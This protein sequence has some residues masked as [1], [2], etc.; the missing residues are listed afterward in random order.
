MLLG[1]T[2]LEDEAKPLSSFSIGEYVV[3]IPARF[4]NVW[5]IIEIREDAVIMKT[6]KPL[7]K[8]TYTDIPERTVYRVKGRPA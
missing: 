7:D 5:E 3:Y 8:T 1:D 2:P 4:G 6:L